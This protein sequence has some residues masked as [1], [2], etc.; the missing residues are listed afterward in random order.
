MTRR[1]SG[2]MPFLTHEELK[3]LLAV[4]KEKRHQA[5]FLLAYRHRLRASER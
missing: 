4:I 1:G 3:H 5:L 2:K